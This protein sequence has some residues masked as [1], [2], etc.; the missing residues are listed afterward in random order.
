MK[1]HADK[2]VVNA[3]WQ[4]FELFWR[5]L[6]HRLS[7]VAFLLAIFRF[8]PQAVDAVIL[9]RLQTALR[10]YERIGLLP[11]PER[12][13]GRGRYDATVLYRLAIF[14]ERATRFYVE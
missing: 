9:A 11:P 14:S 10:Y 2:K 5:N 12:L 7:F 8:R 4:P 13:S 6:R 3:Q 1:R